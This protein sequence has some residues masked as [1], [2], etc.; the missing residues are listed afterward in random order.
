[1]HLL[2]I[3][4]YMP[5]SFQRAIWRTRTAIFLAPSFWLAVCI[6]FFIPHGGCHAQKIKLR[7]GSGGAI[8]NKEASDPWSRSRRAI[9]E[10]FLKL[11]PNVEVDIAGAIQIQGRANE[12]GFLMSMAGGTAPDVFYVNFRQLES[13]VKQGFLYPL[14]EYIA[15]DPG[16]LKGI[17]PRVLDVIN[18]KRHV[19]SMPY[20]QWVMA[21]YYRKDLFKDAGL[22]PNHG[23]QTWDEFYD[24]SQKLTI[25]EKGQ[26]GFLWYGTPAGTAYHMTDFFWQAGA[27][28]VVKDK[29]GLWQAAFNTP[30]GVRAV[31][32]YRKMRIGEWKR[33]GKTIRGVSIRTTDPISYLDRGKVGMWMTY[34]SET[35]TNNN[36][37]MNPSLIGITALPAGP[38]GR[39]NEINASMWGISSQIKDKRVR[40]MAWE[41]IKFQRSE[42]AERIR[43]KSFVEAGMAKFVNPPLLKKYG[44]QEYLAEVPKQWVEANQNAFKWG[45]PEPHGENCQMIY[46]LMDEPLE[47]AETYPNMSA[48]LILDQGAAKI[49]AKL[50]NY[51]PPGEM[52]RKRMIAW[53]VVVL[54]IAGVAVG[55][56]RQ[57]KALA[58]AQT[59]G[60]MESQIAARGGWKT[61][62]IA[63][64]FMLP[65]IGSIAIW[66]YYPLARGMV[67]AFQDY[68]VV[69]VSRW[70]GLD[71][72]IEAFSREEFWIGLK[73][74]F[75]YTGMSLTIGFF[76]PII[77]ALMLSEIPRGKML[78]RTLFYLPAVTSGIIIFFLWK[79][80]YDPSP[81]GLFNSLLDFLLLP[82]GGMKDAYSFLGDAT[83]PL[84]VMAWV[85]LP[86]VWA[87]AGPGCIIYLAA[88]KGI[89]EE[90]YEA[91][92][93]D[94]AGILTKIFRV[95]LP[96][97]KPLIIINLVGAF[98]GS[99]KAMENIFILT[100]GGPLYATHTLGLEVWYN[101]FMYL[102][103]GYATAAAWI[104]G[105]MLI[106][107]TMYQ[108]RILR[109][110]R[111]SA[112][113][114]E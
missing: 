95:T 51:T 8:P 75:I 10:R 38:A 55:V 11:H 52:R 69:G 32:F 1:M 12:S 19:Y 7:L 13:Y 54:M 62:I 78:F 3:I 25:P 4:R 29:N 30:E 100:G 70:V 23:P 31:E 50:L 64:F 82:F 36:S 74:S 77:L 18:L 110:I 102:K 20:Q 72:F 53:I 49:N 103:F 43:T 58:V 90:M 5:A 93:V 28:I 15:R 27:E 6:L 59:A 89:P 61:H 113:Q 109:D 85:I 63:W 87:G 57:V 24:Y 111:F 97:L 2:T 84:A 45:K 79:W 48:K 35:V 112:A 37:T 98:I 67:M 92:E 9:Y 46:T 91:A 34:L 106:G 107:F 56:T 68:M 26:F 81:Q 96:S 114:G 88:L 17:H 66:A 83:H 60:A 14:D 73:N 22:D 105:S 80:F 65:A 16:V 33:H 41:F 40:D 94:G 99:F 47:R 76:I 101:A 108:L 71:N 39:A 44:Y 86:S 21:L 42:E 104:M